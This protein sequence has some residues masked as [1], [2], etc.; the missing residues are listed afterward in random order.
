GP[1]RVSSAVFADFD[2]VRAGGGRQDRGVGGADDLRSGFAE[3]VH[4][5][6]QLNARVERECGFGLVH[7]VEATVPEHGVKDG[8]EPLAMAERAGVLVPVA[9]APPRFSVML[10]AVS[11]RRKNPFFLLAG[12]RVPCTVVSSRTTSPRAVFRGFGR[13][14]FTPDRPP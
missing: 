14:R 6:D 13:P 7:D 1:L 4:E 10:N 8:Q 9:A 12:S 11:A 3:L 2:D 5:C